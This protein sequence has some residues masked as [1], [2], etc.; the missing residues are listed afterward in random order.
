MAPG[1]R[2]RS[3]R[4]RGGLP[5]WA[6]PWRPLLLVLALTLAACAPPPPR[7]NVILITID[8]LRADHLS[9]YGYGLATSPRL[10]ALA[11]QG[12]LFENA[13]SASSC[14]APSH[15]SLFT[16][17]LPSFHTVG[18]F[19]SK[20]VLEPE[21]VTLAELLQD[22]GIATAAVVS[23]PVLARRLGLDQ[24][25]ASYDDQMSGRER[26][27]EVVEQGVDEALAKARAVLAELD[28]PFFFWLHLQDPHGPYDPPPAAPELATRPIEPPELPVG[29]DHSGFGALPRYQVLG[30][31][32]RTSEYVR[33]YD[34]EIAYLDRRLGDWLDELRGTPGGARTRLMVTSDHGEA[35]G[36]DGFFFA[37]GHSVGLDQV[38]VPL[39]MVGEGLPAGRRIA[40]P[41]SNVGLFASVL[42]FFDIAA[43]EGAPPPPERQ[44]EV[45]VFVESLGQVGVAWQG[46]FLRRDRL[47]ADHSAWQEPNPTTGGFWKPLGRE[48]LS[49]GG[50]PVA[51]PSADDLLTAFLR[52]ARAG[53]KDAA[54]RRHTEL[55]QDPEEIRRLRALGY[56][57]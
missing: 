39:I 33:R 7:G 17:R 36:E 10:A 32:R 43:P 19:N 23:N 1:D 22:R 49:L 26:N 4:A 2:R 48:S 14:T 40:E 31:E 47:P 55:P 29:E 18:A 38:Q 37:H 25:F 28:E 13:F 21:E 9:A 12:L 56:A 41:V 5:G 57:N 53:M 8:T 30:D 6:S 50:L 44:P 24:G 45:P 27:R 35:L 42:D 34:R 3:R 54:E 51:A 11:E 52:R 16:G 46:S 20:F 15:A